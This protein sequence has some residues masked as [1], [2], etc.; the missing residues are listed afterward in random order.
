MSNKFDLL[1]TILNRLD[2]KEAVTKQ[3][4][5]DDM[6]IGERSVFRYIQT[7]QAAGFPIH[8]D[9]KQAR[10]TFADG[11][12][13]GRA[14]MS[15]DEQLAISLAKT[16]MS[17]YGT[18][19]E[20]SL[21]AIESKLI[22]RKSGG[23]SH[24]ILQSPASSTKLAPVLQHIHEAITN[25]QRVEITYHA[26][27]KDE[28]TERKIDPY[29]LFFHDGLWYLRA[30]CHMDKEMR[31]FALD[32]VKDLQVLSQHFVPEAV[33]PEEELSGAFGTWLD[34]EPTEVVL[35]FDKEVKRQV[36]RKKW[37]KSQKERELKNGGV[38]LQFTVKGLG[39]I[40]KWIYQW[41]PH[42]RVIKPLFFKNA[43]RAELKRLLDK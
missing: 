24:V 38:E 31:T 2:R 20:R 5:M 10:Y 41:I 14:N 15:L 16:M 18:G 1:M 21:S 40:K 11:Y 3:N 23:P 25:Y 17:T 39:G 34:G 9:R 32:A 42:V 19:M 6:G 35:Q 26:H 37:H 13:L 12:S 30:Y 8:Y 7:L 22:A 29:Y 36:L 27:H 28:I 33:S 43:I 4:L